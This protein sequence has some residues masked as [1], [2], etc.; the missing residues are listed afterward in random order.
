MADMANAACLH[1]APSPWTRPPLCATATLTLSA[2]KSGTL[3]NG[4]DHHLFGPKP[5]RGLPIAAVRATCD[6]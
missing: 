1:M 5:I 4:T 6:S 3:A 2:L